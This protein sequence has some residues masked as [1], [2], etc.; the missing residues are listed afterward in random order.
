V[1]EL[2]EKLGRL[3]RGF[4][5][6]VGVAMEHLET[7]D[8]LGIRADA[9][10]AA[11]SMIKIVVLAELF[12]RRDQGLLRLDEE[13]ELEKGAK[14]AG[15]GILGSLTCGRRYTLYDL[16]VLM[17]SISDNTATNM[18]IG[19]LGI[20]AVNTFMRDIG[21]GGTELRSAIDLKRLARD[22]NALAVGTPADFV[23]LLTGLE[24]RVV[25]SPRSCNEILEIMKI[26]KYTE[27]MNR[28][29]PFSPYVR[30]IGMPQYVSVAS[31]TGSLYGVRTEAGTVRTPRNVWALCVMARG[32]TD[33]RW[34]SDNEG[35]RLIAHISREVYE[36]FEGGPPNRRAD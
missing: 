1:L 36:H 28:F 13:L 9:Q 27:R 33:P 30:D 32:N 17:M 8:K 26:Q 18:L 20:D 31:K 29:L 5:G 15:S 6:E 21:M 12:R 10:C 11:A 22:S 3:I 14:V 35:S 25:L 16:G 7:G 19:R 4:R 24:R 34:N 2:E 23:L